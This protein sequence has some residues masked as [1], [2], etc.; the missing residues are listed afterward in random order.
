MKAPRYRFRHLAEYALL[1]TAQG[2][3]CCIPIPLTGAILKGILWLVFHTIWPLKRETVARMREVFGAD[4]PISRIRAITVHSVW[5]MVMNY[6]EIM[7]I[8]R[9]TPAY[10]RRHMEGIDVA[11]RKIRAL[12]DRYGGAVLALPHMGNWDLAGVTCTGFRFPLMALARLQNNPLFNEWLTQSRHNNFTVIDR[13][14]PSEFIR[15]VHHLKG[16]GLFAILPDVRHNKPGVG[17][18]CFGK[19]NIQ[20]G[21]GLT[22]FS[23]MANVPILP[24]CMERLSADR[25]RITLFEPLFPDQDADPA[26]DAIRLTQAV[27]DIFET[28]IRQT[29][30]Q[31]FWHNRRWLLTP[32]YTQTR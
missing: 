9:M 13:R 5:N 25:H 11:E 4:F 27:W 16:G 26:Q 10:L 29:P 22:K 12:I 18:T 1:R 23:R 3:I 17:V 7:H 30:E 14:K 15:V 28:K 6:V 19:P 21:K 2:V 31:W 24:L 32:L 20:L 8:A